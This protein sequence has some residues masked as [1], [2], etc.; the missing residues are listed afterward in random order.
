MNRNFTIRV[1]GITNFVHVIERTTTETVYFI[2]HKLAEVAEPVRDEASRLFSRYSPK[3]ASGYRIR[4]EKPGEVD[5]YQSIGPSTGEHPEWGALQMT[6]AFLPALD[7][8]SKEVEDRLGYAIGEI[9]ER[10]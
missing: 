6:E 1:E 7:R 4:T 3:S 2:H 9:V 5:V 8:K 10:G